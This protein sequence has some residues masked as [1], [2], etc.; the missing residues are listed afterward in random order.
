MD[1]HASGPTPGRDVAAAVP[2]G[3]RFGEEPLTAGADVDGLV[4]IRQ[5][6]GRAQRREVVVHRARR[7]ELLAGSVGDRLVVDLAQRRDLIGSGEAHD[8]RADSVVG[9]ELDGVA[10]G[11]REEQR[12]MGVLDRAGEDRVRVDLEGA[13]PLELVLLPHVA[14]HLQRLFDLR[15]RV[16]RVDADERHLLQGRAPSA[17][18]VEAATRQ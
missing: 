13:V 11:A 7:D 9:G 8:Q 5:H 16:I 4:G 18:D 17:A 14:D 1:G 3:D 2:V 6:D 15:I 10:L 12:G